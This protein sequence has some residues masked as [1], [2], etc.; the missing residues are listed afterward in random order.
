MAVY[1]GKS[2][3]ICVIHLNMYGKKFK[4]IS[5]IEISFQTLI[6]YDI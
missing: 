4:A 6:R 3:P 2:V 5:N 1:T